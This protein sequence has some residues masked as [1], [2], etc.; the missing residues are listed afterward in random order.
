MSKN[1]KKLSN[2]FSTGGGGGHF[3]AHIQ[4]SFVVLMLTG[5]YAPCLPCYPIKEIK[6]QGKIDGFDTDDLIIFV[7]KSDTREQYR[8]LGQVKHSISITQGS[9]V[10]SEVIRAAWN[11]FNNPSVFTKEKDIIALIT[12]SL[13]ATDHHNVGF[14]LSQSRHTKNV[15][16]FYRNVEQTNFSPPKSQEKLG[17]FQHHLK[18][19]NNNID[20]SKEELYSFLNHFHLLGYDLGADVGVVLSLLQSHIS[21]FNQQSPQWIWS[22]VVDVVQTWNQDA[23]TIISEKLPEDLKQAFKQPSIAYIPKEFIE[24][25]TKLENVDWNQ[26]QYA[27]DLALANLIGAW[28][29]NKE[30]DTAI[31]SRITTQSYSTWISKAREILSHPDSPLALFNGVWKIKKRLDLWNVLERR[32]FDEHL[33][34]FKESAVAVLT[35]RNP[36]FEL[37]V[38]Q[39]FAASVYGKVFAYSSDLRMALA[40]G[41]AILGNSADSLTYCSDGKAQLTATLSVREILAGTDWALWGSLDNFLPV[42]AE[43]APDEFL[44]AVQKALD[45][46]PCPFDELFSQEGDGITGGNYLTGLLWALETLAWEEKYLVRVCVV[47]GELASHDPGGTWANRPAN[48]LSTILLPWFPQTLASVE[49]RQIAVQTLRKEHPEI[50]WKLL[51]SLLPDNHQSSMGSHKPRWRN[52]IPEDWGKNV[53]H[54]EYWTQIFFYADLAVSIASQD[55][56]KLVELIDHF[57]NLPRNSFDKLLEVLSSDSISGLPESEQLKI[58]NKLTTFTSQHR[59]FP[60]AKWSLNDEL[61]SDI[62]SVAK[63]LASSN[64]FYLRQRLFS[65][66][67]LDFFEGADNWQQQQQKFDESCRKAVEEILELGGIELVIQFAEVVKSP[68]RVGYFLGCIADTK[69][70]KILLPEHLGSEK[71]KPSLFIIGYVRS[72]YTANDWAWVD[73]LDRSSWSSKQVSQFLSYLPFTNETWERA[74]RWL[75]NGEADYWLKANADSYQIGSSL[76]IAIDKLIEYGRPR[77]AINCLHNMSYDNQPINV[78]QCVRALLAVLSSSEASDQM[79]P[80]RLR[81]L[82]E[83]LQ[84]T[85]EVPENDLFRIEWAYLPLLDGFHGCTPKFLEKRLANDPEFF[86]ELIRLIYRSKKTDVVAEAPSEKTKALATNAWKLLHQWSSPPGLQGDGNFN[87]EHF[88]NW[89]QRVKE[90][91]TESGHLEFALIYV[92]EVLIHCPPD[93]DGLWIN[94]AVANALNAKDADKIRSGFCTGIFNSRGVHRVDP[95]GFQERELAKQYRQKAEQTEN[96][97][98]QRFASVLSD[99]SKSYEREAQRMVTESKRSNENG[100]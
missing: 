59:R 26:H 54:Q 88:S 74:A 27:T 5:G 24:T 76:D 64:P 78:D 57:D 16:E 73:E 84:N 3:E 85:P 37:P 40:E 4:A 61:L 79:M 20:V 92:G 15:E 98:Y 19:A 82:I 25:Q 71:R 69:I 39:R 48:S 93:A 35:E 65:G 33:D 21:Q 45:S 44:K 62:E 72:R 68:E 100:E 23:G 43:A 53:D 22:R 94:E 50:L 91:C 47:L 89:I 31:L 8:L 60:D 9:S 81:R 36:S 41:L 58:W 95:T 2:P 90:I 28:D 46:S 14:L 83:K 87:E 63:K 66:L 75:G 55:T 97:G 6:L 30:A 32:I 52:P 80:H 17:V 1:S 18:L 42:I 10:F 11:D 51:I 99:I 13:N 77:A 49:K 86:C 29:E 56:V 38:E 34:A 70:D 7:E 12:G 67:D 96:A